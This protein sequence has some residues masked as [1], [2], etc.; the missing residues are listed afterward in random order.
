ME[1]RLLL[2]FLVMILL[3]SSLS[4]S[5]SHATDKENIE[6]YSVSQEMV[7]GL[8]DKYE[9]VGEFLKDNFTNEEIVKIKEE[10]TQEY[11]TTL[12]M[13]DA[14]T[15]MGL[16]FLATVIA[17][18]LAGIIATMV[19]SSVVVGYNWLTNR[20]EKDGNVISTGGECK[21]V[22]V[23]NQ[24]FDPSYK[25]NWVGPGYANHQN[26]VRAIQDYSNRSKVSSRIVVDGIYGANTNRSIL[27]VQGAL[28]VKKDGIVGKTTWMKMGGSDNCY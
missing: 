3:F 27:A 26:R 22:K 10:Y 15:P 6:N 13:D 21:Q 12:D 20:G 1:K 16:S 4:S 19:V 8:Q 23:S 18:A 5:T 14:I 17:G 2:S 9:N 24:I 7:E 11:G 28:G 25:S